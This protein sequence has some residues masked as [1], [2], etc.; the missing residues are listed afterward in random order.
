MKLKELFDFYEGKD[1]EF[2]GLSINSKTI[3]KDDL[4]L[5]IKG[6]NVD[7]HDYIDEAIKNGAKALITS[8]DINIDFPYIK[9]D[10]LD[11][12]WPK[13][14]EK[15]YNYPQNELKIIGITGTD[16]KTSVTTIIQK[17]IGNNLCGY[18]GTN[19][20]SCHLFDKET[21]NTTPG[22]ESLYKYLREFVDANIKYVALETSSEAFYYHRLDDISFSSA[23]LTNIAS[24]H[25]NTH[26]TLENYIDC[27]KELFRKCNGYSILNSNDK[28]YEDFELLNNNNLS[29]GY[30]E[31]DDIYIKEF[32][33]YPN[34]TEIS[35]IYKEKE[36]NIISSLLGK[37]NVENLMCAYLICLSLGFDID[38]LINNTKDLYIPGRMQVINNNQDFYCIVDFAHNPNALRNIFDFTKELKFNKLISVMGQPGARDSIKRKDVGELLINNSDLAILTA[39]DP[40]HEDVDEIIDMMLEKVK[41][42]DNYIRITDR[43]KA[44]EYA[45]NNA[46]KD[47]LVLILGKGNE[48]YMKIKDQKIPFYDVDIINEI[49]KKTSN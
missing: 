22:P 14:Y 6:V 5:C 41:D 46:K 26:K 23:G 40:R 2:K 34:K 44:I 45:L 17:L 10:N 38:T 37:F 12:I 15:Y 4:F 19:G 25:L 32:K 42:A 49:L 13:L 20:Y 30:K 3:N 1:L 39:D 35:F 16:G 29:Y 21:N 9:I 36:Y 8:K 28:Y 24:E 7:R 18:I 31:T 11:E 33:C 47:D 43:K 48:R 27:K